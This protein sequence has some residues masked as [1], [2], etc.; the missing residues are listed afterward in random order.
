MLFSELPLNPKLLKGIEALGFKSPTPVQ[1]ATIGTLI[2]QDQDLIGLA[3]TGTGKT[4]AFGLPMIEKINIK[5]SN[6]QG[7]VL[8][9]LENSVFRSL[10]IL[11]LFQSLFPKF[12]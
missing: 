5:N 8:L 2:E 3:Q 7:L 9:Q 10:T 12:K 6:V 4:A 1:E 11:N